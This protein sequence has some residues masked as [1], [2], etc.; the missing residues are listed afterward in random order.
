MRFDRKYVGGAKII[1]SPFLSDSLAIFAVFQLTFGFPDTY[2][3]STPTKPQP[4]W[5]NDFVLQHLSYTV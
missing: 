3:H 1:L 2:G 5:Q 4:F